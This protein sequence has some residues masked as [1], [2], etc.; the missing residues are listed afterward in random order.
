MNTQVYVA[1]WSALV[2][3]AVW[4]AADKKFMA[5]VWLLFAIVAF[6]AGLFA[7]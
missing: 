1:M 4:S 5:L 2:I 3:S 7:T 6:V